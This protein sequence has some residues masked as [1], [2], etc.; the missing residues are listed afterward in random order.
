MPLST[1]AHPPAQ[2]GEILLHLQRSK[3]ASQHCYCTVL[4]TVPRLLAN[5]TLLSSPHKSS[6][7]STCLEARA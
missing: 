1:A 7:V 2:Q 4:S 3:F 6:H 5:I